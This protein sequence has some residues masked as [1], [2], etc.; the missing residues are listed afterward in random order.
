[1][2]K[3]R[4]PS[5]TSIEPVPYESKSEKEVQCEYLTPRE[6]QNLDT[7]NTPDYGNENNTL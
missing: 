7:V 6:N 2:V 3:N 5:I 4:N 1:M